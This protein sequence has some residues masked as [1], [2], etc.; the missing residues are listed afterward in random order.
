MTN[1]VTKEQEFNSL[2]AQRDA[3]EAYV[4][5]QQHEGWETV[6]K[7][8]DDRGFTGGNLERPAL[9]LLLANIES[10]NIECMIV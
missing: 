3:A 2:D 1:N 8:Y 4:A 5:S 7:S 10:G 9:K 6:K